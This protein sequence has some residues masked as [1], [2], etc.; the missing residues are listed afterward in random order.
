MIPIADGTVKAAPIP[1]IPR[2]T[3]SWIKDWPNP[4]ASVHTDSQKRPRQR[5]F[6]LP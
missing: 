3:V 6:F 1:W 4:M 5:I 2:K